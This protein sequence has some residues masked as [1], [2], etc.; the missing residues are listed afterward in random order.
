MVDLCLCF[1][2]IF[3]VYVTTKFPVDDEGIGDFGV[4]SCSSVSSATSEIHIVI[5]LLATILVVASNYNM[6]CLMAPD[7]E[8]IDVVHKR[9]SHVD[10]GIQSVHN[11]RFIPL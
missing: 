1:N 7:R 6:Q 3:T 4:E 8:D 11:L 2:I 10:I 5:N 9:G